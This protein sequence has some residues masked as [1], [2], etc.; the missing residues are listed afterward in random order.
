MRGR[1]DTCTRCGACCATYAVMFPRR[2]LECEP[3]GWVPVG[4]AAAID[5]R[6][7]QMRGRSQRPRRC[8]ALR[9]TI[10]RDVRCAIYPQRPSPCRAFAPEAAA[11]RGDA[12]CGDARR[13]HGLP[14]LSGSYDAFPVA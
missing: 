8:A 12:R 14:P 6:R 11:G 10:G 1:S 5:R 2:E 9:G 3:G 13:I 4:F 7:A